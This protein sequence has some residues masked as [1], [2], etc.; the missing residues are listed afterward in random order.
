MLNPREE[1][2]LREVFGVF[3]RNGDGLIS[4]EDLLMVMHSLG[5]KLNESDANDMIREGDVDHDG[6][7]SFHGKSYARVIEM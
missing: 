6:M 5:M 1:R 2:E 3:D 4:A 7:I